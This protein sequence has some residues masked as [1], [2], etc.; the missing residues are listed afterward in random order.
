MFDEARAKYF[1]TCSELYSLSLSFICFSIE[2]EE[3]IWRY[4]PWIMKKDQS[5]AVRVRT[6]WFFCGINT[7]SKY[8]I[9]SRSPPADILW[10]K[11]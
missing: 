5:L 11:S 7:Y 3:L 4:V 2:N 1:Q 6:I 8:E 10:K 9:V